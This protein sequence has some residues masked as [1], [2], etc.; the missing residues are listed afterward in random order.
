MGDTHERDLLSVGGS[1]KIGLVWCLPKV[2]A[3]ER[4]GWSE[5]QTVVLRLFI[6]SY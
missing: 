6:L 3:E 1:K 5:G 2:T 4:F